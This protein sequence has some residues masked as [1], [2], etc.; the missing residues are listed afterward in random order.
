MV[1]I[2]SFKTTVNALVS[3]GLR[4]LIPTFSSSVDVVEVTGSLVK[5]YFVGAQDIC[6]TRIAVIPFLDKH[7]SILLGTGTKKYESEYAKHRVGRDNSPM[8]Y[9]MLPLNLEKKLYQNDD[10]NRRS[11]DLYM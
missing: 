6:P 9:I 10:I 11:F 5:E 1:S 2:T 7:R 8:V 3:E 4:P